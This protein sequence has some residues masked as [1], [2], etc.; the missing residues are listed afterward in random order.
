MTPLPEGFGL[1]LDR[2]V[3]TFR[4]GTVLVG[5]HPGRLVTL[6]AEGVAAL[7]ALLA[8]EPATA[9]SRRLGRRL[10][11]AGMAHPWSTTAP[12]SGPATPDR[13]TGGATP[14]GGI[15]PATPDRGT[16]GAT[17]DRG[18]GLTVV[19]PVHNA[20]SSLDRCLDSLGPEL[21]VVVVDDASDDPDAVDRVCRRHGSRLI[22]RTTNGGPA[23]ARNQ[24]LEVVGT[25]LVAFVDSDCRVTEGWLGR[26]VW[27][28][29][30][31]DLGAVAPRVRP[32]RTGGNAARR[33]LTRFAD[34]HSALDMG[35]VPSEV[36][37]GKAVRYVPTAALLAR[38]EALATG[39]DPA[40]RVGEDVDLVWRLVDRG[41]HV[42]Y[43]PSAT[44]FHEEPST[45]RRTLARRFRYGTSAGP[46]SKRHPGRL[47]PVELRPWPTA[48]AVAS[49]TGRP[50][51]AA[52]VVVASAA[53]LARRVRHHGVPLPLTVRWSAEATAWTV[54]GV[55]RAATMLAAPVVVVALLRG[56]RAA[57][58]LVL[59]PAV[60]EWWR[61]RP[62][63]DPI[64][65]VLASI[66]DDVVYGA[67]VWA[68][69]LRWR[70]FGPLVPTVPL[71]SRT[72]AP[73]PREDPDPTRRPSPVVGTDLMTF[74]DGESG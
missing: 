69:C 12:P 70:S 18:T 19:V 4:N 5:G 61:R 20:T 35:A 52:V 33:V 73:S 38:R 39:F 57:A 15:G 16:G 2:S 63:L 45:W 43:E 51:T 9:G 28:F 11:D 7:S 50:R 14:D 60:V 34:A 54:V 56:S 8:G 65:W 44:V 29:D 68:G 48:A 13:G 22:R 27:M 26:L 37:P 10:V 58:V 42:R 74:E 64:R 72:R 66:A 36:G 3:R 62:G 24:A 31:P 32:D 46:L 6:T 59:A 41:W 25:D 17:P 21:A 55:G 23:A 47:S 1:V 53:L 40:L 30:D 49:L 67:G 71:R